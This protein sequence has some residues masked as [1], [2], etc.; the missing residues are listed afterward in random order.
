MEL[1]SMGLSGGYVQLNSDDNLYPIDAEGLCTCPYCCST[2]NFAHPFGMSCIIAANEQALR[3][4]KMDVNSQVQKK[5]EL[6]HE[7]KKIMTSSTNLATTYNNDIVEEMK[8]HPEKYECNESM[9]D[10]LDNCFYQNKAEHAITNV[11]ALNPTQLFGEIKP[12]AQYQVEQLIQDQSTI[13]SKTSDQ[14]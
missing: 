13:H 5:K 4:R 6:F 3:E 9:V 7:L 12:H 8:N 14:Q 2:C 1:M 10:Y 11:R